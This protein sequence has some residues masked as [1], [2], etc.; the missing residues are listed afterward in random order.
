[1]KLYL[2][3]GTLD[4]AGLA[5]G[6][7]CPQ[8]AGEGHLHHFHLLADPLQWHVCIVQAL[9]EGE[10]PS[11]VLDTDRGSCWIRLESVFSF[12]SWTFFHFGT[13]GFVSVFSSFQ[14]DRC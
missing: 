6:H 1:M 12:F 13:E 10:V 3:P 14:T 7:P 11:V 5:S 4:Q 8:A 2:G 9:L